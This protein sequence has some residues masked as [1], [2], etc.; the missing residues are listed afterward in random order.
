MLNKSRGVIDLNPI[1]ILVLAF[2]SIS[3]YKSAK[4]KKNIADI[5]NGIP[6]NPRQA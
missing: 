5:K 4:L 6:A 2:V 1:G 3:L